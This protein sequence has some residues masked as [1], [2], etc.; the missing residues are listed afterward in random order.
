MSDASPPIITKE[1]LRELGDWR[2]DKEGRQLAAAGRVENLQYDPPILSGQ[3]RGAGGGT[4]VARLKIGK[5]ALDTENLCRCRQARADGIIC[6]HAVALVYAW[7]DKDKPRPAIAPPPP[8]KPMA[9]SFPRVI[10]EATLE[11]S[12]ILPVNLKD[13]WKTGSIQVILEASLKGGP[14]RPFHMIPAKSSMP[15]VVNEADDKL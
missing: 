4:V 7:L 6:A 14:F 1:F 3:V 13:A 10:G 2:A 12:V 11:L 9:P 8:A 5:S 15:Y